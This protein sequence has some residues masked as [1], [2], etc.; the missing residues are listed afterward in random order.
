M[1]GGAREIAAVALERLVRALGILRG[2]A[3]VAAH[4]ERREQLLARQAG[5]AEKL[6]RRAARRPSIASNRCSTET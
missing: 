5:V 4:L 3:L 6:R 1:L 2:D